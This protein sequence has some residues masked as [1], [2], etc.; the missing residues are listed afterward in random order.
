MALYA[1]VQALTYT[2]WAARSRGYL[3]LLAAL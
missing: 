1:Q 2:Q 3:T